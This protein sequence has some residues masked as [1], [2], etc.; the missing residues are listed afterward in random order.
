MRLG[1]LFSRRV[2]DVEHGGIVWKNTGMPWRKE[3][4]GIILRGDR[5]SQ[6]HS[7]GRR[8]LRCGVVVCGQV[9]GIAGDRQ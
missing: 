2:V 4:L 9:Q 3:Q 6:A 7:V 1:F 5:A 8:E